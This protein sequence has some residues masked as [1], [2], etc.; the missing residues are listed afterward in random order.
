MLKLSRREAIEKGMELDDLV[1]AG[2]R[3]KIIARLIIN[4]LF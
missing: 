2:T 3:I 1:K 4:L